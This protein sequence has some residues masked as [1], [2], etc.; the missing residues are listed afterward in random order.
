MKFLTKTFSEIKMAKNEPMTGIILAGGKSTRFNG[1]NKAFFKIGNEIIIE[2]I[3]K[4]LS[5]IFDDVVIVANDFKLPNYPVRIVKD[6]YPGKGPLGGIYTGLVNSN[7]KYNF[8]VAC[9]MP[10]LNLELIEHIKNE[11][12]D[13]EDFDIIVPKLGTHYEPLHAIYSKN[14]ITCIEKQIRQDNL[15]ITELFKYVKIKEIPEQ[16]I[17]RFDPQLLSFFNVNT[18]LN[19]RKA[20]K[21][22]VD[23]R[24]R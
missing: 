4:K 15:K 19:Y 9:D 21:I 7:T 24:E 14:C 8:V 10:F 18:P 11:C 16:I 1:K 23:G 2:N 20:L 17:K 3:I 22:V 5:S 12:R 13:D 6:I